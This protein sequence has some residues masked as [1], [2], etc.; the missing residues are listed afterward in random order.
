VVQHRTS[1]EGVC[2]GVKVLK[3]R[4]P[5]TFTHLITDG[6]EQQ[7]P[8][9]LTKLAHGGR[10]S[11]GRREKE[12]GLSLTLLRIEQTDGVPLLERINGALHMGQHGS[13]F[14]LTFMKSRIPSLLKSPVVSK[15][16]D[17]QQKGIIM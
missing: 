13:R 11:H 1:F 6:E 3:E 9:V 16:A 17:S 4:E 12:V 5:E 15:L 14:G 7:A 2:R 10:F 8:T